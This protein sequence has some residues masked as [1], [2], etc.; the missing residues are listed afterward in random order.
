LVLKEVIE[1]KIE[2]GIEV[3]GRRRRKLKEL[4][5]ELKE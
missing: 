2:E 4:L 5:D 1:G 3:T